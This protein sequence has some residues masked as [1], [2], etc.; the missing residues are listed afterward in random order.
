M[1]WFDNIQDLQYYNQPQGIPCYCEVVIFP[2]DLML[3]G[4]F[5]PVTGTYSTVIE[6][7]SAD[8]L[9]LYEDITSYFSI[10]YAYNQ[11]TNQDFFS[12]RMNGWPES[13][14]EHECFIIKA[15]VTATSS[16]FAQTVFSKYTERYCQSECCDV[17][18]DIVIEQAGF[19]TT[20]TAVPQPAL[21]G[22]YTECGDPLIRLISKHTCYDPIANIFFGVPG[23]VKQGVA[24][25]EFE[26]VTTIKGRIVRKPQEILRE[27]SYNCKLQRV[28]STPQYLI[29]GF[30]FLPS[31]K[32]L[33]INAQF[34]AAEIR[35]DDY[36]TNKKYQY[37]GGTPVRQLNSCFEI[38]KLEAVL[39]DCPLRK[40]YGCDEPCG[41]P[42]LYAGYQSFLLVPADYNGSGFYN[43][44][45]QPVADDVESLISYIRNLDG[46]TDAA[47][48]AFSP[49][50]SCEYYTVIGFSGL[51]DADLPSSIYYNN[52]SPA[53]RI[54]S[55]GFTE[56]DQLCGFI[57]NICPKPVLGAYTI[58]GTTCPIP[59]LGTP[60]ITED[61]SDVV[62]IM[63]Y[64][65]WEFVYISSPPVPQNTSASVYNNQVTFSMEVHDYSRIPTP[66]E[67]FDIYDEVIG[68]MYPNG[69][70]QATV[71]LTGGSLPNGWTV[72][73][74]QYGLIRFSGTAIS[75]DSSDIEI[76]FSNLV[77]NI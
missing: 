3:Q 28:T 38:Y 67:T 68:V 43:D 20:A 19:A 77:Y 37:P 26:K 14:C 17:A 21:T 58:S 48:V 10:Y 73:V 71:Y 4:F 42:S 5:T 74:D 2:T 22:K 64:A 18:R 39:E 24:D 49:V 25:F 63:E 36:T 7:Y 23:N 9:T 13:V 1:T 11:A 12:A 50:L 55:I 54:Y 16:F 52:T 15:T 70:P 44:N 53:N 32:M 72:S 60:V 75:N 35:V 45:R 66:G 69:R 29:E 6:A 65:P 40:T 30:E 27:R 56:A 62:E 61:T 46:M 59:V 34:G 51:P 41:T 31:W 47:E 33:E 57:A 76:S 8:G